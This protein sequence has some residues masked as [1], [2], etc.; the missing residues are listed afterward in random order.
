MTNKAKDIFAPAL[1]LAGLLA[2]TAGLY[3]LHPPLAL[4][5]P[6]LLLLAGG[7]YGATR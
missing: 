7:V 4:I 6:G 3:L 1:A 5:V 2:L